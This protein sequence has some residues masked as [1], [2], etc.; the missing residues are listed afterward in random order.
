[1]ARNK[2]RKQLLSNIKPKNEDIFR[3]GGSYTSAFTLSN[4]F[5]N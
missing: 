4:E 1:M 2:I 5:S 3:T